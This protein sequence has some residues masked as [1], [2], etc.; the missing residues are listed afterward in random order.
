[1]IQVDSKLRNVSL[2][3][4][5]EDLSLGFG[6]CW[7]IISMSPWTFAQFFGILGNKYF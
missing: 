3:F 4:R 5:D 1:M 6:F 7:N 2:A